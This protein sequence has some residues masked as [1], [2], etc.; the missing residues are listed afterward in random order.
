MT[1]KNSIER[2]NS[3]KKFGKALEQ[4]DK[5]HAELQY[6]NTVDKSDTVL[7]PTS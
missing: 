7:S 4:A 6:P 5:I 2:K 3:L 1:E